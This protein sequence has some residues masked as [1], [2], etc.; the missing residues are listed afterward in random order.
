MNTVVCNSGQ[1][2]LV[3]IGLVAIILCAFFWCFGKFFSGGSL[4]L[5]R[6]GG[7]VRGCAHGGVNLV[8]ILVSFVSVLL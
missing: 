4:I 3:F 5:V 1:S 8:F 7:L 2:G 6:E